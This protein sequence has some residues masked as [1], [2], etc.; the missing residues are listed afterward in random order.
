MRFLPLLMTATFFV[1]PAL[2]VD[3]FGQRFGNNT[4]YALEND[5]GNALRDTSG[6][7]LDDLNDIAPASG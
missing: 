5:I 2:A 4:P 6:F 3:E 7:D 1:T